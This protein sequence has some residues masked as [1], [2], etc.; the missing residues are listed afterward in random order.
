M[1]RYVIK[2]ILVMIPVLIGVTFIIFTMLY[3]TPGDPARLILGDNAT[4][5]EIE[6]LQNEMGLN[7]PFFT[8]Y[9][10]YMKGLVKGD[11]GNSYVTGVPVIKEITARLPVTFRLTV[12]CILFSLL[13]GIPIGIISA[14]KQ[15]SFLDNIVRVL[16]LAGITM[17]NFWLALLLIMFFSL[18]LGWLPASGL[19]GPLFYIMPVLSISVTTL[20]TITRMTRSSMLE[21]VRQDYIRTARAK[22]Q[23][24]AVIIFKHALKNAMIPILT[25]IGTQFANSLSGAVVNEQVFAL[26]GVGKLMVDAIKARN[27]PVVQGG[28]LVI[29]LMMLAVSLIVDLLYAFVDPRIKSIYAKRINKKRTELQQNTNA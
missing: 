26:P 8:Q 11:L 21:V 29:A 27:Y 6:A 3:F 25:V 12:L 2:R 28:V 9:G 15:Y 17:P 22:G 18:Y 13:V 14:V 5:E 20:A 23:R 24:E 10:N 7:D 19:Y 16:A 4:V 1:L